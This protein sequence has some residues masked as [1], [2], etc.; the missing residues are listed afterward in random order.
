MQKKET[1][2]SRENSLSKVETE[3]PPQ[4]HKREFE[5]QH[6]G[7]RRLKNDSIFNLRLLQEFTFMQFVSS[8]DM[9]LRGSARRIFQ[10]V[11]NAV[12]G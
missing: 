1:Q 10:G 6:Q 11:K 5:Q 4:D 8:E 3:A 7:Q 9:G 12:L 2:G